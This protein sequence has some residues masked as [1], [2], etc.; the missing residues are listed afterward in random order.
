MTRNSL[1]SGL[2]LVELLVVL[3]ILALLTGV[4]VTSLDFAIDQGRFDVSQRGLQ[5]IQFAV[6]GRTAQPEVEASCFLADTG[7]LPLAV[8]SDPQT[9]LAE[10]WS[11]PR[12]LPAFGLSTSASDPAVKLLVG[13]R[14]P[15]LQLPPQPVGSPHRLLDGWGN[16]YKLLQADGV[17]PVSMDQ[18]VI[19]VRSGGGPVAPYDIELDMPTPFLPANYLGTISGSVVDSAPSTPSTQPVTVKLFTPDIT[20]PN[21]IRE[22]S[23]VTTDAV[24][25]HFEFVGVPIGPKALR[26]YQGTTEKSDIHYVRL[27]PGGLTRNL[28]LDLK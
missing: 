23:V 8:G 22:L 2:T 4:A 26:A 17:T 11:N 16:P 25:F 14:G 15:Y 28:Y 12:S 6:L 24:G 13:W 9:Q 3:V 7:R 5:H 27:L 18:P 1:R 19:H 20:Q 21:G 10:L